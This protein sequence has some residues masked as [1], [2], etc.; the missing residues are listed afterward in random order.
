M[1][2]ENFVYLHGQVY[3]RP[4]IY[5]DGSGVAK[6][7]SFAVK[8][9]RR[10]SAKGEGSVTTGKLSLD[11]PTIMTMDETLI[12]TCAELHKGDMVDI[13]G[14][15]T[16]RE[17]K[18]KSICA[19]GHENI[20]AGNFVFITPIYIC[21]R[22]Q[23]LNDEQGMELLR[24]RSEISNLV[25]LIGTLCREP[26]MRE[27]E[28]N[29]KKSNVCQYQLAANRRYHIRDGMHDQERTDYPWIKTAGKQAN[30]DM[31]RLHMGSTVFINGAI[32]TREIERKVTCD[33]CGDQYPIKEMA[34]EIFPYSVE[35]LMNCAF[36]ESGKSPSDGKDPADTSTA[37]ES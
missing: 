33:A 9:L 17:V 4:K 14:V 30:E 35:Y 13:R 34:C 31:E 19:C 29:G 10:P 22:E 18:K 12:R 28:N 11:V 27:F 26:E 6:K 37:S 3:D 8:V 32:Q 15:Y 36:P 23:E 2:K 25:L 20:S 7:A 5:V 1:A 21:Q 16:T 24:K